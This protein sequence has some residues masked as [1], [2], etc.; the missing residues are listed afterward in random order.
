MRFDAAGGEFEQREAGSVAV[1]ALE[2]DVG[3]AWILRVVDG[4]NDDR[5]IVTDDVAGVDA[6]ARLF[7][8]IG[9]DG[10]D[11]PFVSKFGRDEA[12]LSGFFLAG[13]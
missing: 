3:V 1:L 11:L 13:S 9:D 6:A 4:E 2:D 8:F 5:A 7:D 12:R 10:E